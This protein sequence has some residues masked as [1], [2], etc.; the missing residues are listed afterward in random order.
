MTK[1][2][3]TANRSQWRPGESG[4]KAGRPKGTG[5][6]AKLRAGIAAH[7][8]D[9]IKTLIDKAK[10]GDVG[11]ARLL[12]ERVVPPLR[13]S[14]EAA[15]LAMPDGTLTE[16][17]RAVLVAVA[18]G[19]LAPGQGAALLSSLG[20]LAKLVETDELMRRIDALE[21]RHGNAQSKT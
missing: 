1:P 7:V 13:A 17:G 8:P 18:C 6:V 19:E 2:R 3:A 4:N 10:G 9:L 5:E 11:A 20:T 16:Q 21:A 15:Q 12:L 14:E